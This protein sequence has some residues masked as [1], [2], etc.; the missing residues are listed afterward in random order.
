MGL[1]NRLFLESG[2]HLYRS[3]A[4]IVFQTLA[5]WQALL[6]AVLCLVLNSTATFATVAITTTTNAATLGTAITAGNSG[7][8]LTGTPVLANGTSGTSGTIAGTFTTTGSAL[9]IAGGIILSTGN[10]SLI[11]GT[12]IGSANLTAAGSGVGN[13]GPV[14]VATSE[15]DIVTF[16]FSFIPKPGVVRMS[17]ASVFASEE[18]NEYVGSA[19]TDNFSMLLNG[20][21][22]SN[23]NIATIPGTATG[24]DINSVSNL[25]NPGYY[26]DNTSLTAPPIADIKFDGAT[27]VFINA[28]N[29]V[30]GTTY[31]L[32]I[33]IADAGDAAYDSAVFV[34][35]STVLNNP[36]ALDLSAVA[37][38]TGFTNTWAEGNPGVAIAAA[39]DKITDDGTTI[40][41][42]TITI[43]N[44]VAGD[45]LAAGALPAGIT[46]SAYNS[47]TGT[48]TL[49]GVATLAQY[50]TALQAVL[51][52]STATNPV[53]PDKLINVV[54]NDGVDPS[55]TAVATIKIASL[56]VAKSASAPTVN[57]GTSTTLTD[58]GDR[59]TYTY[60]VTNTGTV[61]LTAVVPVDVGP[62]FNGVA[63]TGTMSAY[64]PATASIA[65][66]G[67]QTFTA[68]YTLSAA[69][70]MNGAGVT[71]G[72]TNIA[73]ANG[74]EP[75]G[76]IASSANANAATSILTVAGLTVTKTA[77]APTVN[78]GT[79]T[80]FTDA[81]DTITF[82]YVVKNVGSVAL[83]A[84]F[85]SDAGPKFNAIAGTNTLSAF[86]PATPVALAAGASQTFTAVYILSL[87]DMKNGVGIAN[88]V[89]N[90][91]SAT[92]KSPTAVTITAPNSSASTTIVAVPAMTISKT[93]VLTDTGGLTP[94]MADLNEL[95]TYTYT[96]TNSGNVPIQ[97]I[98][99]NDMHGTPAAA[100]P[101]GAGGI[102]TDTL[103]VIG[104]FGA[105][106]S[107]DTTAN[108][109]IWT[110]LAPGATITFKW[111]HNVNQ[112][113]MD[114]G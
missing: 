21:A 52:S 78:L 80:T 113:E 96:I 103:T 19:Y 2:S 34:S 7:I 69:D 107:P 16:T 45:L 47:G 67:N 88:G 84:V 56:T 55:N 41:S 12:P 81:N 1:S 63:G 42:A 9:G 99:V 62:K 29:V 5:K 3:R 114:N 20:G 23:T 46:A 48:I 79:N 70:V 27:T 57:L 82:T 89:T 53:G 15:F 18:Y 26:R 95:L 100:V 51:Y 13:G 4:K 35:T 66:G 43:S 75:G 94:A 59:I 104:P 6:A 39:D 109:G 31:T 76:K 22:Y 101:L 85:P 102:T 86:T 24:T 30:P 33:R 74:T 36:P 73:K 83:T 105:A 112:A 65:I 77:A 68:T 11:P 50:Q 64:T 8:T 14:G 93:F 72:V 71:N 87:T 44:L 10:A 106:A 49:T 98:S 60:V 61:A 108:D 28:F 40:S 97:N 91:A 92:G 111:L 25:T 54:V 110:T 17:I 90:T 37:S 58:T 38:G 32:T